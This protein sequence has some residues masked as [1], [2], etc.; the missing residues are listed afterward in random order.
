MTLEEEYAILSYLPLS[1]QVNISVNIIANISARKK[2][3]DRGE[4]WKTEMQQIF[5]LV[6]PCQGV[7]LL[8]G[9]PCQGGLLAPLPV[10]RHTPVKT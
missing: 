4:R 7:S 8:G 6:S 5:T 10:D 9:S 1:Q 2:T 3:E